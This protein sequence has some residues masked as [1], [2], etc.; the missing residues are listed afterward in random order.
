VQKL[1]QKIK[2]GNGEL[3]D[4]DKIRS[5]LATHTQAITLSLNLVGLGSQG[6]VE[7]YM[8]SHSDELREIKASLNWVTAKMQVKEG[9]LH[10][11]KS[12]LSSY[13]GD[14]KEVWK[15]FRRELI[16]DGFSS[17]SLRLH[18]ETI[19][20]YVMELGERGVLDEEIPESVVADGFAED[21]PHNQGPLNGAKKGKDIPT[22]SEVKEVA[23]GSLSRV[24]SSSDTDDSTS[25]EPDLDPFITQTP[26]KGRERTRELRPGLLSQIDP[27]VTG[28]RPTKKQS[29]KATGSNLAIGKG[30]SPKGAASR[31]PKHKSTTLSV[32]SVSPSVE[33]SRHQKQEAAAVMPFH[34]PA[35]ENR[36]MTP[37]LETS[38]EVAKTYGIFPDTVY[39]GKSEMKSK[40]RGSLKTSSPTLLKEKANPL[41][42]IND[43]HEVI[44]ASDDDEV[45]KFYDDEVI[46]NAQNKSRPENHEA[47]SFRGAAKKLNRPAK[48]EVDI[49]QAERSNDFARG[50]ES[51]FAESVLPP[52]SISPSTFT[53]NPVVGKGREV[54]HLRSPGDQVA[55]NKRQTEHYSQVPPRSRSSTMEGQL[56]GAGAKTLKSRLKS[57]E[58]FSA[59]MKDQEPLSK[60]ASSIMVDTE[61]HSQE[62]V[63]EKQPRNSKLSSKARTLLQPEESDSSKY[64]PEK[65]RS[66]ALQETIGDAFETD[67]LNHAQVPE[68][69]EHGQKEIPRRNRRPRPRAYD[70]EL[71]KYRQRHKRPDKELAPRMQSMFAESDGEGDARA[72]IDDSLAFGDGAGHFLDLDYIRWQ[73]RNTSNEFLE[74]GKIETNY[75][76]PTA[77][78]GSSQK[79]KSKNA[80]NGVE[81]SRTLI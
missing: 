30:N 50:G 32:S 6:K 3:Q 21:L 73:L 41:E 45:V 4:L 29:H 39:G 31:S 15:L 2:F 1:W 46:M 58:A 37:P 80:D 13:N 57:G 52:T 77:N 24:A 20:S 40:L 43:D 23:K 9:S 34:Q 26:A 81:V 55:Y 12:V 11:E 17:K 36:K 70:N 7:R 79:H 75:V 59:E 44:I 48:N 61:S 65:Y 42:G 54:R 64:A 68:E 5:E 69:V 33:P 63:P 19:K 53:G 60:D 78:V 66:I 35:V 47:F 16:H 72:A 49:N 38:E 27:S 51:I 56:I 22:G 74:T 18:K 10:G 62:V 71:H 25:A 76:A 8:S 67:R 14:D 28:S